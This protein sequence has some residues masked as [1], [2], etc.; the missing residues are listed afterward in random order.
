M[1][2]RLSD[3]PAIPN[4]A[5]YR[6]SARF[7]W[8]CSENT[9]ITRIEAMADDESTIVALDVA[10]EVF[11]VFGIER[12]NPEYQRYR[13][14]DG[15]LLDDLECVLCESDFVLGVDWKEWLQYA[16][17]TILKQLS[18][19]GVSASADL[20]KDGNQGHIEIGGKRRAIKYVTN[21]ADDFDKVI[22]SINALI[23]TK[24]RYRKFRSCEGTDGWLYGLIST[25]TW[26]GLSPGAIDLAHLLFEEEL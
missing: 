26:R 17:D 12:S 14:D 6:L 21:D 23:R 11:F 10:D 15:F 24:G 4:V 8:S 19:I 25:Q 9:T 22:R 1:D 20:G 5:G 18:Y 16:V 3:D 7:T 13:Q 2:R